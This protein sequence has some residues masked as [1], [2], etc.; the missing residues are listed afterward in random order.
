[1]SVSPIRMLSWGARALYL[2]PGFELKSHRTVVGAACIC[3][4]GEMEVFAGET[5]SRGSGLV[6][7]SVYIPPDTRHRIDFNASRIACLYVDRE[8]DDPVR[9]EGAMRAAAH[10][11]FVEHANEAAVTATLLDFAEGRIERERRRAEIAAAFGLPDPC[12]G[13]GDPRISAA[14]RTIVASPGLP[15]RAAT[16]A[17]EAG[18]SASR[19]RRAFREATGVPLRRFRV[20]A[21]VGGAMASVRAGANLTQAAHDAGFSS[22]AH[23]SSAYR[24]MFGMTPSAFVAAAGLSERR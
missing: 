19:F 24:A 20:W 15:H 5:L 2:G 7:R 9:L 21:R 16:L 10:G 12:G 11:L 13:T 22:S 17:A 6:C 23:F 8:S 14:I 1:M 3:L 4:D 18:L